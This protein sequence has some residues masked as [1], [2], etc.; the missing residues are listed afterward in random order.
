MVSFLS[1]PTAHAKEDV[2]KRFQGEANI[3]DE[4]YIIFDDEMLL[5]GYS[6]KVA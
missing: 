2:Q 1:L 4:A 6:R 5:D 3:P